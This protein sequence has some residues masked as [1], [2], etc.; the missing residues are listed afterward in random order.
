MYLS[1]F[2]IFPFYISGS[3]L[4][5]SSQPKEPMC[6]QDTPGGWAREIEENCEAKLKV[7]WEL[8]H[9]RNMSESRHGMVSC[10]VGLVYG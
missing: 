5:M 8:C 3:S 7:A 1:S 2:V 6:Y 10:P 4:S 9:C